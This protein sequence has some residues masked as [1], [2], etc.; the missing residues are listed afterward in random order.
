[1]K[2]PSLK[3]VLDL[4]LNKKPTASSDFDEKTDRVMEELA[5]K[6]LEEMKAQN[7]G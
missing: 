6:R 7:V 1:V 3:E 2:L 4:S 5:V